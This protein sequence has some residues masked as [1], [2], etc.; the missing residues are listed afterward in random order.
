MPA[1]NCPP[2]KRHKPERPSFDEEHQA[3]PPVSSDSITLEAS[4]EKREFKPHL[5]TPSEVKQLHEYL[6][7]HYTEDTEACKKILNMKVLSILK[8]AE[9][10]GLAQAGATISA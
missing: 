8:A 4:H 3:L 2:L 6:F 5:L 1:T 7:A 10:K 9:Q